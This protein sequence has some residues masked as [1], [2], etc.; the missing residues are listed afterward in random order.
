[1]VSSNFINIFYSSTTN[2]RLSEMMVS[3][4]GLLSMCIG[5]LAAFATILVNLLRLFAKTPSFSEISKELLVEPRKPRCESI[6]QHLK[7]TL[8][9]QPIDTAPP[10]LK[11]NKAH[12]RIAAQFEYRNMARMVRAAE[13]YPLHRMFDKSH[14]IAGDETY[15]ALIKMHVD[16]LAENDISEMEDKLL[17]KRTAEQLGV[18]TS[19]HFYAAHRGEY[20]AK[21]M[22]AALANAVASGIT[23]Y[24]VKP[25]HMAWSTGILVVRD[26]DKDLDFV[27]AHIQHNI[28]DQH[29]DGAD[30]AHLLTLE[31]GVIIEEYFG[32]KPG[33]PAMIPLE[34]KVQLVWG[35]VHDAWF[36]GQ[37]QDGY[38]LHNETVKIYG[39]GSSWGITDARSWIIK[40]GHWE[41]IV[42]YSTKMARGLGADFIRADFFLAPG[43]TDVALNEVEAV[44]GNPHWNERKGIG[45]VWRLGYVAYGNFALSME[46]VATMQEHLHHDREY[47]KLV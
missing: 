36:V 22:R 12:L 31:P 15:E 2:Y 20:N 32:K 13:D 43:L 39:D 37:D 11:I 21:E 1:L 29:N 45:E 25:T 26:Q 18:P 24:I 42:E 30:N 19:C 23:S 5:M 38:Q 17:L 33:A 16:T 7:T 28:L 35:E 3:I 40:E 27:E 44:N 47:S 14:K 4:F 34:C 46:K 9:P 8:E 6:V 10:A 41:R